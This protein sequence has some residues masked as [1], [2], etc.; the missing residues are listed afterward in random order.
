MRPSEYILNIRI[1]HAK[2]MLLHTTHSIS[3]IAY[4]C[5]FE[6]DNYFWKTFRKTAGITPASFRKL[7]RPRNY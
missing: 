5:G 7:S 3:E 2:E 4:W 6:N 1:D